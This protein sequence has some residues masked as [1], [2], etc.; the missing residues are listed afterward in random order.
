VDELAKLRLRQD[1]ILHTEQ[2]REVGVTEDAIRRQVKRGRWQ[3][4]LP[5]IVAT[6]S[7]E[8]SRKQQLISAS[9]YGGP[10]AQI[11]GLTALEL[12]G[13]RYA[14]TDQRVHLLVPS[15]CFRSSKPRV[16]VIRTI[17]LDS[18]AWANGI[19]RVCR[20][21]RAIVDGLRGNDDQRLVRA[22]V[23]E[24]VQHAMTSVAEVEGELRQS[25]RNGTGILRGVLEEIADGVR[26]APE[27][28][29][30]SLTMRS[31]I[32]PRMRW[33]P[34]LVALDGSRL[35][36]PDGYLE[37]IGIAVEVDSQEF[38]LSADGWRRTMEHGNGLAK[39]GILV[40]RFTPAQIRREPNRV[41]A[42]LE[43]AYVERL[44]EGSRPRVRIS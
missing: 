17:R 25:V 2:L 30:R 21:A 43:R 34:H 11:A 14:P 24:V 23:A 33:N 28:E 27:A 29:L 42:E 13:V 1:G 3:R 8:L 22:V 12:H 39:A 36:T 35:P 7:G 32:L 26:S 31:K 41:L 15:T 16:R 10:G 18:G 5:K 37:D 19:L 20:P 38:H 4:T 40:L 9:L 6:F 44:R